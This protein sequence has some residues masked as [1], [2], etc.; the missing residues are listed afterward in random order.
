[1]HDTKNLCLAA[2]SST[3][4]IFAA[5]EM[6]T[7]ITIISAVI[8]PVLFFCIGKT[9]DVLVQVRMRQVAD[10]RRE[11]MRIDGDDVEV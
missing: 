3:T 6:Q 9:V 8:L 11:R 4:S 1:M 10:R 7:L 5:I 2:L